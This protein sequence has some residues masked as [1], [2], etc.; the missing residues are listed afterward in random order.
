MHLFGHVYQHA[1]VHDILLRDLI[2]RYPSSDV[3]R[4][5]HCHSPYHQGVW[6][7]DIKLGGSSSQFR[8]DVNVTNSGTGHF[9]SLG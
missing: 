9:P 1:V 8:G 5:P 4:H 6:L 7:S 2:D 3:S